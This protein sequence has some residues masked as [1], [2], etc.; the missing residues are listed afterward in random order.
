MRRNLIVGLFLMLFMLNLFSFVSAA[1]LPTDLEQA[2]ED[3]QGNVDVLEGV[4]EDKDVRSEYLKQE[5]DKIL[6]G[7]KL[8]AFLTTFKNVMSSLDFLWN[9][10]FGL[11]FS[12]SWLFFLTLLIWGLILQYSARLLSFFKPWLLDYGQYVSLLLFLLILVIVT[13]IKIPKFFAE[14]IINSISGAWYVQLVSILVVFGVIIALSFLSKTLESLFLGLKEKREKKAAKK[15]RKI[16]GD[17]V[18]KIEE[19]IKTQAEEKAEKAE[20]KLNETI[21]KGKK[22]SV[23]DEVDEGGEFEGTGD[24]NGE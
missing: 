20:K 10:L 15:E 4:I 3:L 17:E 14:V 2:A 8:G 22:E 18:E 1:D 6:E 12:W 7:S 11:I 13:L 9:L 24:N 23:E 16:Q 19:Y 5:W 21:R